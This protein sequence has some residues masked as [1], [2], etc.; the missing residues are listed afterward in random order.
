MTSMPCWIAAA[1][2]LGACMNNEPAQSPAPPA[3]PN[4]TMPAATHGPE[5]PAQTSETSEPPSIHG[6]TLKRLDGTEA[7]LSA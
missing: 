3:A 1:L 2:V 5:A 4:E 7:P 6:L